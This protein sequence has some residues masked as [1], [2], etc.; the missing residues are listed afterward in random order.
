MAKKP[1]E[2]DN[3]S[4]EEK[5]DA[6]MSVEK[7][8][9]A[10]PTP[11]PAASAA[12]E[13]AEPPAETQPEETEPAQTA[14]V[15]PGKQTDKAE[16]AAKD[17]TTSADPEQPVDE[18]P[19]EE[20]G[21]EKAPDPDKPLPDAGLDDSET[22]RA[23]DDI[24]A[25]E[26]D[27][28]LA[29]DDARAAKK[30]RSAKASA[31]GGWK[32][33]L[34]ALAKN[35]WTWIIV[36]VVLLA[37]LAVP[38]TRYKILGLVVKKSVTVTVIDSK[39]NT[40]VSSAEVNLKGAEAKTD[41]D[42]K[43]VVKAGIGPGTLEVTK[44]YYQTYQAN[45]NV[46][47]KSGQ[48]KKVEL[49]ATGRL[50][51]VMVTN[52]ITGQPLAGAVV[53]VLDTTAK[54]DA[55]GRAHIALPADKASYKGQISLNGYNSKPVDVQVTDQAV[56][57]N[58][59]NITPVG[60]VYF[61]S[62]QT[63]TIDVVRSNL[64]G[65]GRKTILPGTGNEDASTTLVASSD[66]R[67]LALQA[68]RD[69]GIPGLYLIDTTTG[70][71]T[72]FDDSDASFTMLGWNDHNLVYYASKNDQNYWQDGH[73][74]LKSYD[75]DHQQLNLLDQSQ[76]EGNSDSY[77]YQNFIGI[78]LLNNSVVYAVQWIAKYGNGYDFNGKNDSI[79]A[80]QPNGQNKKDY[81]SWPANTINTIISRQYKPQNVYFE[82]F[83]TTSATP[84][85][86]TYQNNSLTQAGIS[87]ADMNKD[88]PSYLV[89][90]SG[91]QTFWTELRD[92]KNGLF[93]GG[94]NA[95]GEQEIATLSDYSPYGWFGD[96]YVL[97]SKN[98]SELYIMPSSGLKASQQ[99]LKITDYYKPGGSYQGY[100]YG[101]F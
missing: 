86:Y 45:Y 75:A 82:T 43:A 38:F 53:K 52:S 56:K 12:P 16:E 7:K 68:R 91:K 79:R 30:S 35:K 8:T 64:D 41:G 44:Q 73:Q 71:T 6:Y 76:A 48:S 4:L 18:E 31:S 61:L 89:S 20:L 5:V 9:A 69:S 40:P 65:S 72:Q 96:A 80:V 100:G 63:G 46:S 23:V 17:Q 97:L 101:Y 37:L 74:A 70:K 36:A 99:P 27:L 47:F 84:L 49:K 39:T 51:P 55:K 77:A 3:N 58:D 87:Q 42:G 28:V 85:F 33:K 1:A 11:A 78:H 26:A 93:V 57:A 13:K 24:A 19:Q 59:F 15:L 22:D 81:Q 98:G 25:K 10:V 95:A 90:P 94:P 67:F 50:V 66:W 21:D 83:S 34:K 14:P 62:N 60:Q 54:T 29:V 88:Y 92:G 2:S 32:A